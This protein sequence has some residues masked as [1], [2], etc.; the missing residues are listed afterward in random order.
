MQ[1]LTRDKMRTT[2]GSNGAGALRGS[3]RPQSNDMRPHDRHFKPHR[4]NSR[5]SAVSNQNSRRS[6]KNTNVQKLLISALAEPR[7]PA[8]ELS[9]QKTQESAK[10]S[11]QLN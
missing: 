11:S 10:L 1:P 5:N 4:S 3:K 2:G 9:A 7:S 6:N 8:Q